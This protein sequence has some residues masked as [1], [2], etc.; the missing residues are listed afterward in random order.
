MFKVFL[1]LK[2][3]GSS[4]KRLLKTTF[5]VVLFYLLQV[6]V[7]PYL[8]VF[9]VMPNLHMVVIAILTVSCGRK[10]AFAAGALTGILLEA[11][12]RNINSF[13]VLIYPTLALIFAQLFADMSDLKREIRR[14]QLRS[15]EQT[16]QLK[17]TT[18]GGRKRFRFKLRFK[19]NSADDL[20][21]HLRILLNAAALHAAYEIIMMIYVS[22]SGIPVGF[23]HI[24]KLIKS[25]LY[26]SAWCVVMFPARYFL[27]MYKKRAVKEVGDDLEQYREGFTRADWQSI[28]LIPDSPTADSLHSFELRRDGGVEKLKAKTDKEPEKEPTAEASRE[29]S[30]A[31]IERQTQQPEKEEKKD[32]S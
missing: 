19:R 15:E 22:L 31:E 18:P 11:V 28:A 30:K 10:F 16:E 9:G 29:T 6:C 3:I 24:A 8:E 21:P 5:L 26:T 14:I 12:S 20:N 23:Y 27:G 13:Y 4:T 1:L 7:V 17:D 25:C 2:S 32:E